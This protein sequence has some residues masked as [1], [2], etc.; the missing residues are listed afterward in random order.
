MAAVLCIVGEA[1]NERIKQFAEQAGFGVYGWNEKEFEKF[2]D[3]IAAQE[4]EEWEH[5][6]ARVQNLM[7]VREIQPN[8]PCCLAARA[9]EREACAKVAEE[10]ICDVHLPTG[11][12]IYGSR[13]A[14]AIRARGTT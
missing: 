10:T 6:F 4:R 1:M 9:D 2:A 3:L 14:T 7:D 5:K 8:K 12:K 13:V 11:T